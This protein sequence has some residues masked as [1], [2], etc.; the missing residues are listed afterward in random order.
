MSVLTTTNGQEGMPLYFRRVFKILTSISKGGFEFGLPDGRVFKAEGTQPG[1]V[2]RIDIVN[3]DCIARLVRDGEIG[4]LEAYMDGDWTTPDLQ[5]VTDVF[6]MN[7][8]KFTMKFPGAGLVKMFE[9]I[10][11]WM[12]SNSKRQARKNIS[13]HYDLGNEFYGLW[14]DD[15]MT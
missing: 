2:A 15:T 12:N 1:P 6:L 3:G 4:F 13:Y 10:R 14:L 8:D 7:S 5:A 9:K 11:H